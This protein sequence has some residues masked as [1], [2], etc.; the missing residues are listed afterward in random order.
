MICCGSSHDARNQL[1]T[2]DDNQ[3]EQV[4]ESSGERSARHEAR[5]IGA[6]SEGRRWGKMKDDLLVRADRAI[7]DS[8][9]VRDQARKDLISARMATAKYRA[10][11]VPASKNP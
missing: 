9:L 11:D 7:R 3:P 4:E 8:R 10:D 5:V 1:A 6:V 2:V